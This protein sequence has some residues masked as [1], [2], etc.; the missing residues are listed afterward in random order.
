MLFRKLTVTAMIALQVLTPVYAIA[1]TEKIYFRSKAGLVPFPNEGETTPGA[2]PTLTLSAVKTNVSAGAVSTGSPSPA[3]LSIDGELRGGHGAVVFDGVSPAIPGMVFDPATG[4]LS[5]SPTSEFSGVVVIRYHDTAGRP[6][7][8]NVPLSVYPYPVL[9]AASETFDIWQNAAV[10][11]ISF[12]PGNNGFYAGVTYSL[13]PASSPLPAGLS[14]SGNTIVGTPTAAAGSDHK[15][16]IRGTSIANPAVFADKSITLKVLD[17]SAISLDVLP[18]TPLVWQRDQATG[19]I[20]AQ[21]QFAPAPA[22]KGNFTSPLSWT[23]KNGPNWLAIGSNGQLSGEPPALGTY[24]FDVEVSDAAGKKASDAAIL[25][26]TLPGSIA[27][28]FDTTRLKLRT[29]ETFTTDPPVV[30]NYVGDLTFD[31]EN[32]P[33][34]LALDS[35]TGI[36]NGQLTV[37]GDYSWHLHATDNDSRKDALDQDATKALRR[38]VVEPVALSGA[39]SASGGVVGDPANPLIVNWPS[40]SNLIG[41]P[42]YLVDGALPGPLYYRVYDNDDAAALS[43]YVSASGASNVRQQVGESAAA[44]EARLAANH[45]VFDT[46][47]RTLVGVPSAAGNYPLSLYVFDDHRDTGYKANPADPSR[48]AANSA[49]SPPVTVTAVGTPFKAVNL[50]LSSQSVAQYTDKPNLTTEIQD[51]NGETYAKRV[52]WELESGTLPPGVD[53]TISADT[54]RLTYSNYPITQGIYDN[55]VWKVTDSD[56][57]VIRTP[58]VKFTIN[59]RK[60]VLLTA[61]PGNTINLKE[62]DNGGVVIRADYLAFGQVA[63]SAWTVS[64]DLPDGMS[65]SANVQNLVISGRPTET[66]VFPIQVSVSDAQGGT[67]SISLTINVSATFVTANYGGDQQTL[68]QWTTSPTLSTEPRY[69]SSNESYA[70]GVTWS[71]VSGTLPPGITVT[72][73]GQKLTYTGYATET[74]TWD[75]IVWAATDASGTQVLTAPVS[76]VITARDPLTLTSTPGTTRTLT[77]NGDDAYVTVRAN[78][79]A[80]GAGIA[81]ADWSVTG[82]LPSG[83]TYEAKADGLY[84]NGKATMIGDFPVQ[85]T[86]KDKSGDSKTLTVT[87]KVS[88]QVAPFYLKT[89]GTGGTVSNTDVVQSYTSQPVLKTYANLNNTNTGYPVTW[90][91]VSGTLPKGVT[92][93]VTSTYVSYTGYPTETGTFQLIWLATAADG[94]QLI[95]PPL[96]MTATER[97]PLT[98]SVS[99][100]ATR[101]IRSG[102]DDIAISVTVA[103]PAFGVKA[104]ANWSIENE[105]GLPVGYSKFTS[106]SSYLI[107]GISAYPGRYNATLVK[108]TD[109]AGSTVSVLLDI[110]VTSPFT[111]ITSSVNSSN[112]GN[113]YN[114]SVTGIR[115]ERLVKG[116]TP[117]ISLAARNSTNATYT[118]VT[119]W[120]VV[121]GTL[122]P[123]VTAVKTSSGI[124]FSG[125]PT[126]TGTWTITYDMSNSAGIRVRSPP[127]SFVVQ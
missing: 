30:S 7:K 103:N 97:A 71:L 95:T 47:N 126:S 74:G 106:G 5:G 78:N 77:V 113:L 55:I 46:L 109:N 50:N 127:V 51:E 84:F 18:N 67:A 64:G 59:A 31:S 29:K 66:G 37:P 98:I 27:I 75:N 114:D 120:S 3:L 89:F 81:L 65:Q 58:P 22:P 125:S 72:T 24:N 99:P 11:G 26:V 14:L 122:P 9:T 39:T 25:K 96:T 87:F 44:A 53:A 104:A 110:T 1:T 108:F 28:S 82:S 43:T 102:L 70:P 107:S 111:V 60:N 20:I 23:I 42:T 117:T 85:I 101:S 57:K 54:S 118:G 116:Q 115:T 21:Q 69:K 121:T 38:T 61:I 63:P 90:T 49:T 2:I 8:L 13:A 32:M 73:T 6:G 79:T 92:A 40:P 68:K 48:E 4:I 112:A 100:S 10:D 36:F 52:T 93:N 91:L 56:G 83:I 76:F 33:E 124:T 88:S 35:T 19:N 94:T 86:A 105:Q 80:A 123:G 17:A 16:T 119:V 41:A 34:S 45:M 62:D 15:V 12:H